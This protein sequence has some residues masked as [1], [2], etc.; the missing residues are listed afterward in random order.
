MSTQV[1]WPS[2]PIKVYRFPP[3]AYARGSV[4]QP[5]SRDREGAAENVPNQL[6]M[7]VDSVDLAA[8]SFASRR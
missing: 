5:R 3:L 8:L 1:D 6:L 2:D 7:L 4:R